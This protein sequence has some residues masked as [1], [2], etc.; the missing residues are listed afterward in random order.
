MDAGFVTPL[1]VLDCFVRGKVNGVRG[2][3]IAVVSGFV[4]S[5]R[6]RGCGCE[7]ECKVNE[8]GRDTGGEDYIGYIDYIIPA[9]TTTLD[10][11]RHKLRK[12]SPLAIFMVLWI[13]PRY[14]AFA[15]GFMICIRVYI[16]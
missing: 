9:P 6:V 14:I 1:Q 15:E 16:G 12:P 3:C 10:M 11:P 7:V 8:T 13:M 5:C 2:S 4:T